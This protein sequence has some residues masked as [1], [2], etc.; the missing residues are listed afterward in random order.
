MSLSVGKLNATKRFEEFELV[1][2]CLPRINFS[3]S[4]TGWRT[5]YRCHISSFT[6]RCNFYI[7][8]DTEGEVAGVCMQCRTPPTKHEPVSKAEALQVLNNWKASGVQTASGPDTSCT[9]QACA[10]PSVCDIR[11]GNGG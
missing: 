11:V 6:Q 4:C 1:T 3:I 9:A 8:Q 7:E 2:T 5:R 10:C